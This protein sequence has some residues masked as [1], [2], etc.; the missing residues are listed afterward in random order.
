MQTTQGTQ[1]AITELPERDWD[2]RDREIEKD[3]LAGKPAFLV[4]EADSELKS[5]ELK[6]L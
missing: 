2:N 3:A 5:G 6:R 4:K 1:K